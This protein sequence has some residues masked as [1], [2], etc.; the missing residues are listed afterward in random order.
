MTKM[1][2]VSSYRGNW[3]DSNE[4]PLYVCVD[5]ATAEAKRLELLANIAK[6][7]EGKDPYDWDYTYGYKISEVKL[8]ETV[9]TKEE[10]K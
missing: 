4:L 9:D 5:K 10:M 3:E 2:V 8:V 7:N 1:Y 6:A